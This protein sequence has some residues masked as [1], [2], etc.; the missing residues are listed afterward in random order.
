M[1][2]VRSWTRLAVSAGAM[3]CLI[4]QAQAAPF[5]IPVT[6][7]QGDA[8]FD[9]NG[10]G[11]PPL[12]GSPSGQFTVVGNYAA[13]DVITLNVSGTVNVAG[14]EAGVGWTTNAA[15]VTVNPVNS[16]YNELRGIGE[17]AVDPDFPP[18]PLN[19]P[20]GALLLSLDNFAT[21]AVVP[22]LA[23]TASGLGQTLI[24]T[25]LSFSG[26][27]ASLFGSGVTDGTVFSFRVADINFFDSSGAFTVTGSLDAADAPE[28]DP[29][30]G[31]VALTCCGLLLLVLSQRQKRAQSS[32]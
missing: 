16:I 28:M 3:V 15:G 5:T 1:F 30:Q 20:Y 9:G 10:P 7:V 24:P 11:L 31:S 13:T 23:N 25:T 32:G 4:G 8:N 2:I 21:S 18:G 22:F 19:A 6:V 12:G 27:L 17:I 29:R 14:N 26:T